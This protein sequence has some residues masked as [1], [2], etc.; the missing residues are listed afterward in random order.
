M[1]KKAKAV[2][3]QP[4]PARRPDTGIP[5][6]PPASTRQVAFYQL[7][8]AARKKWFLDALS[9]ALGQLE[10]ATVKAQIGEYVPA[11]AQKALAV[12]GLRDEHVFPLPAVLRVRLV[13][14]RREIYDQLV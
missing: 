11:A 1:T 9:E 4:S 13:G 12:A 8:V 10:P 2:Q 6:N 14:H 3:H 7:L 5:L